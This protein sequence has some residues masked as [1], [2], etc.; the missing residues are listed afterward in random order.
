MILLPIITAQLDSWYLYN[1]ALY[2]GQLPCYRVIVAII[3]QKIWKFVAQL[4]IPW[5]IKAK[6]AKENFDEG[7]LHLRI[8]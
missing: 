6:Q 8:T 7:I 4:K 2:R 5:K 1:A 3:L